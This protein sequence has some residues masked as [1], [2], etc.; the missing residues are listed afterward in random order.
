MKTTMREAF[1]RAAENYA[2]HPYVV[3]RLRHLLDRSRSGIY[4]APVYVKG[5][6][7]RLK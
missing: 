3:A 5:E 7:W 2:G 6:G 1:E 4:N